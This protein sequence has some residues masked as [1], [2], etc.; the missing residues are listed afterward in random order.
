MKHVLKLFLLEAPIV[1]EKCDTPNIELPNF[2]HP[3]GRMRLD[4]I[5]RYDV[6]LM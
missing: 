2:A 6:S 5:F 1:R 3:Y 4:M